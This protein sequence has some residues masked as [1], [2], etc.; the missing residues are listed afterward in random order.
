MNTVTIIG[1]IA[2]GATARDLAPASSGRC[3][4]YGL[5]SCISFHLGSSFHRYY[6]S[7]YMGGA[8]FQYKGQDTDFGGWAR[9]LNQTL[10]RPTTT[11]SPAS[12][13]AL[14]RSCMAATTY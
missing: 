9:S 8:F 11:T 5:L 7:T 2:R 13:M 3:L 6:S 14:G 10:F 1:A 4:P 12:S